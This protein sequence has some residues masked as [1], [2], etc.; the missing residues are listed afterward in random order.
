MRD[1]RGLLRNNSQAMS[2]CHGGRRS[3][4]PEASRQR[5]TARGLTDN[6][7][8]CNPE[9]MIDQFSHEYASLWVMGFTSVSNYYFLLAVQNLRSSCFSRHLREIKAARKFH[10]SLVVVLLVACCLDRVTAALF[11]RTEGASL[12]AAGPWRWR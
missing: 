9:F 10:L 6:S 3:Q 2:R 1:A 7:I 8:S 12:L 4:K 5:Q 11:F